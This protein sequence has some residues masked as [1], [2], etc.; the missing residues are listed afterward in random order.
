LTLA[1]PGV[2]NVFLCFAA[3]RDGRFPAVSPSFSQSSPVRAAAQQALVKQRRMGHAS[4]GNSGGGF[5]AQVQGELRYDK[6]FDCFL[7]EQDGISY[8][9]VW[10]VG[11]KGTADGPGVD[12]A[13]GTTVRIG[14]QVSGGGGYHQAGAYMGD[15][16]VPPECIPSSGEVAVYNPTEALVV[17]S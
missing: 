12:L 3:G 1:P 8:P 15:V 13:D 10:P 14:Q 6:T 2:F 16:V 4:F 11:T 7:L 9:V 5:D 17:E